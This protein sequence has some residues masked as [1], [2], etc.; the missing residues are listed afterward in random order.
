MLDDDNDDNDDD[1]D[2]DDYYVKPLHI[3]FFGLLQAGEW[4]RG[5]RM[6][7]GVV[8]ERLRKGR[9]LRTIGGGGRGW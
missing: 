8:M 4:G 5:G 7:D 3:F 6:V 1:K 9:Q 2:D